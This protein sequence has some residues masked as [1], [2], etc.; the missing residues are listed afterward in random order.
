MDALQKE[1]LA[2]MVGT[3]VVGAVKSIAR[4]NK[5]AGEF[6]MKVE[7]WGT[8]LQAKHNNFLD[9]L[10]AILKPALGIAHGILEKL[11][12]SYMHIVDWIIE[13]CKDVYNDLTAAQA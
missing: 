9:D 5:R 11:F 12:P 2:E 1:Q 13:L 6:L 8:E 3:L 4:H 7:E 10:I